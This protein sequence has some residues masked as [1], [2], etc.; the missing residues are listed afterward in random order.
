MISFLRCW[1]ASCCFIVAIALVCLEVHRGIF[2]FQSLFVL[3]LV[4]AL[5]YSGTSVASKD[6]K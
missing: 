3:I 2:D 5:C 6:V 1:F 4:Y